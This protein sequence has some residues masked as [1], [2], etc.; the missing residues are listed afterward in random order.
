MAQIKAEKDSV[1]E[2]IQPVETADRLFQEIQVLQRQVSDLECKLDVQA[3]GARSLEDITA[4]LK[5][6]ERT[7]SITLFLFPFTRMFSVYYC[8]EIS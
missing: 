5:S 3:R 4:E 8:I 6:L 2:L 1:D 7:R